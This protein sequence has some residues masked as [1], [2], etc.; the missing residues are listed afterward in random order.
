MFAGI[1]IKSFNSSKHLSQWKFTVGFVEGYHAIDHLWIARY[2]LHRIAEDYGVVVSF[3][4]EQT[5]KYSNFKRNGA[6]TTFKTKRPIDNT[7][8]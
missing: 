5:D 2:I 8:T 7:D 6:K 1:K 4:C 3:E